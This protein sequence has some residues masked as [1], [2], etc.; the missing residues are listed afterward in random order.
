MKNA[1][2][3]TS[4]LDHNYFI[5]RIKFEN[6]HMDLKILFFRDFENFDSNFK[7]VI[8]AF[9]QKVSSDLRGNSVKKIPKKGKKK[10]K[11]EHG[12]KENEKK[13]MKKKRKRKRKKTEK[14]FLKKW[15]TEDQYVAIGIP[16]TGFQASP[17]TCFL[18]LSC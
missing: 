4:N 11:D 1:A 9:F 5:F 2:E 12:E 3:N 14:C 13:K 18:P 6:F 10:E 7:W 8:G 15:W 17:P 16:A